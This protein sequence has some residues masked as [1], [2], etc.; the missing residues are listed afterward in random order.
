MET[1]S[2]NYPLMKSRRL[3][4]DEFR[5][6]ELNA[7]EEE[8]WELIDGWIVKS[9]AG[10]TKIHNVIVFN[11]QSALMNELRR[12]LSPCRAFSE[13]VRLDIRTSAVS[14][15]PDVVVNCSPWG[16]GPTTVFDATAIVEVLSPSTAFVD[17]GDK[18]NAYLTLPALQTCAFIQQKQANVVTYSRSENGWL[19]QELT[20]LDDRL[21]FGGLDVSMTLAEIYEDVPFDSA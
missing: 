1:R 14:T 9:M 2:M 7:P 21:Q 18:L 5:E 19:R 3:T 16:E 15:L 12:S 6:I 13:N 8:R 4:V 11:V 10:G 20:S 17:L